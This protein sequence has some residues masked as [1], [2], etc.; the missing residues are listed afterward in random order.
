M[1]GT[2]VKMDGNFAQRIRDNYEITTDEG[3]LR[4]Y[5]KKDTKVVAASLHD[6]G[7]V[8]LFVS[9]VD[10]RAY[11]QGHIEIYHSFTGAAFAE[12]LNGYMKS[13]ISQLG[14]MFKPSFL[15]KVSRYLFI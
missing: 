10:D 15:E 9:S 3:Y 5:R 8:E 14:N 12:D 1:I 2:V 11:M 7:H 13:N 4:V 6:H